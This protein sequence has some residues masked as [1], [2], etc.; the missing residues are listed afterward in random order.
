MTS[1]T[2]LRGCNSSQFIF[3]GNK[4]VRDVLFCMYL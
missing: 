4:K 1:A 3:R 2:I